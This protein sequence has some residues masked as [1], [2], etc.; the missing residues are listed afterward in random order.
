M[1]V[2]NLLHRPGGEIQVEH[3][4]DRIDRE[5]LPNEA[6]LPNI[7]QQL[8]EQ[9]DVME[10]FEEANEQPSIRS[11]FRVESTPLSRELRQFRQEPASYLEEILPHLSEEL[12][13]EVARAILR[14]PSG[15]EFGLRSEVLMNLPESERLFADLA[16]N[17]PI[18]AQTLLEQDP[19][20]PY[21]AVLQ[22][23]A[24]Q[25]LQSMLVNDPDSFPD[26]ARISGLSEHVLLS[27]HAEIL[28]NSEIPQA[29]VQYLLENEQL[30]AMLP[31]SG[32]F[33]LKAARQYPQEILQAASVLETLPQGQ[34]IL[35]EAATALGYQMATSPSALRSSFIGRIVGAFEES[36][37][38]DLS[39]AFKLG[40]A[41]GDCARMLAE[42]LI[43]DNSSPNYYALLEDPALYGLVDVHRELFWSENG[44]SNAFGMFGSQEEARELIERAAIL[45]RNLYENNLEINAENIELLQIQ[46]EMLEA[47]FSDVP[48]F[49]G[50]NVV[51]AACDQRMR[52]PR[53]FQRQGDNP[54]QRSERESARYGKFPLLDAIGREIGEEGSLELHRRELGQDAETV[55]QEILDAIAT[56]PPGENGFTFVFRGHGGSSGSILIGYYEPKV[57]ISAEELASAIEKRYE[58]FPELRDARERRDVFMF[59]C[60]HSQEVAR[61]VLE[62]LGPDADAPIM[63][64]AT[65]FGQSNFSDF[66]S[67]YDSQFFA[68]ILGDMQSQEG[69]P[70]VRSERYGNAAGRIYDEVGDALVEVWEHYRGESPD[71]PEAYTIGD[72]NELLQSFPIEGFDTNPTII[73]P[74]P[75]DVEAEHFQIA[76]QEIN[77]DNRNV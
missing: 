2:N 32:E 11:V 31:D 48:I 75:W 28:S 39:A 76:Q 55:K 72:L 37:D 62:N 16:L 52:I 29:Y 50:R 8:R 14:S 40:L 43:G 34:D 7:A 30:L 44:L 54:L 26:L 25:G 57:R 61:M 5:S 60:C 73:V 19:R 77:N 70:E 4:V 56:T 6:V 36:M 69:I 17:H 63:I 71:E 67:G 10:V 65:E 22:D 53:Y 42:T 15:L 18:L 59:V 41:K 33:L 21:A 9:S 74:V 46:T 45:A 20:H 13:S 3:P 58:N 38:P 68:T 47:R 1:S 49:R 27:V 23:N 66:D 24:E 64:T 12:Q 51:F 35:L